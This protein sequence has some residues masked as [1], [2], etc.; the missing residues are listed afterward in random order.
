MTDARTLILETVG[1]RISPA[2]VDALAEAFHQVKE[3]ERRRCAKLCRDRMELWRNTAL[4]KSSLPS[5]REEA[6][7]RANEAQYL[8]DAI[9]TM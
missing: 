7:A 5:A 1:D 9:E 8:A 2:D 4:A 6:R 3:D